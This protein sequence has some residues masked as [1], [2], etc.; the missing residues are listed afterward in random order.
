M[1]SVP[2]LLER[3]KD[4][5]FVVLSD[6]DG[7][8]STE[9]SN[10]HVIDKFG[11]G[12]AKRRILWDKV[13]TGDDCFR[14]AFR[15]SLQSVRDNLTFQ[16]CVD[17]LSKG[18]QIKLDPGFLTFY[19]WCR[20]QTPAV[21]VIVVSSGME[22]IIRGIFSN[23]LGKKEA[24][25]IDIVSNDVSL[26]SGPH[27]WEIVYRHPE[28]GFGHDKSLA[29]LPFKEL[30]HR[31]TLFFCGDGI[32]DMSAAQHA[33]CLFVKNKEGNDLATY[34]TNQGF[35]FKLFDTFEYV[36][37][38]VQDVIGGRKTAEEVMKS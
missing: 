11:M 25:E 13:V 14:D 29:I 27:D 37:K 5:P 15:V 26:G 34:C 7:T 20:A 24:D 2:E 22:P 19:E 33:D 18:C 9:D 32:S 38:D 36:L 3:Y 4:S 23:L 1:I 31:P 12:E 10:D 28:S 21:P 30:P 16:E 8:I 6:F 17:I 35:P